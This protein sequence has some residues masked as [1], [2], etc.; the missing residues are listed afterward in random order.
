[1]K[2]GWTATIMRLKWATIPWHE[3]TFSLFF[4]RLILIG[5]SLRRHVFPSESSKARL[6]RSHP[7]SLISWLKHM[8][9]WWSDGPRSIRLT[10]D[11]Q[12]AFDPTCIALPRVLQ[13]RNWREHSPTRRELM[14]KDGYK[15]DNSLKGCVALLGQVRPN[16]LTWA[17]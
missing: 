17:H 1:M 7:Q 13:R 2:S 5:A 15:R 12:S 14:E 4:A 11:L 3:P 9:N 8:F 6:N 16:T 10:Y